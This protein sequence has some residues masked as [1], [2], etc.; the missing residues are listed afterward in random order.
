[1]NYKL[2]ILSK[3]KKY[4]IKTYNASLLLYFFEENM[5]CERGKFTKPIDKNAKEEEKEEEY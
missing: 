5:N 3:T 1:M 4:L 2:E